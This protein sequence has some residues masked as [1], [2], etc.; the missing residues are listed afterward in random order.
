M[1]DVLTIPLGRVVI[2]P[3][4][5][6]TARSDPILPLLIVQRPRRGEHAKDVNRTIA[7]VFE[8]HAQYH[9]RALLLLARWLLLFF[10]HG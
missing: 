4:Y 5:I 10:A 6:P 8:R 2:T 1:R 3:L 7:D 9:K